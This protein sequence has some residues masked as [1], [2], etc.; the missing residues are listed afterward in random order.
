MSEDAV[1]PFVRQ[2]AMHAN[3]FTQVFLQSGV[4]NGTEYV[5]NWRERLR[6]IKTIKGRVLAAHA[7]RQAAKD[8]GSGES[9][10]QSS[11]GQSTPAAET[12]RSPGASQDNIAGSTVNFFSRTLSVS[13]SGPNT[14]A[15]PTN[16][17]PQASSA[18]PQAPSEPVAGS[19]DHSAH[20][21]TTTSPN[22]AARGNTANLSRAQTGT[23]RQADRRLDFTKYFQ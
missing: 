5:S 15:R 17:K 23:V 22:P 12:T 21:S 8:G 9:A 20:P 13:R 1:A 2:V 18:T 7:Q 4:K 6:Q 10:A 19:G 3:I 14:P 11:S 16:L